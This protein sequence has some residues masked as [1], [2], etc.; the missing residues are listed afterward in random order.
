MTIIVLL[1]SLLM[2]LSF[3]VGSFLTKKIKSKA[4]SYFSLSLA[5]MIFMAVLFTDIVPEIVEQTTT[6][7]QLCL[8]I[9]S[10][11]FG[12]GILFII[13][14]FVPHHHHEHE[15]N[16]EN[17]AEH[18][19]HLYHIGLLTLISVLMHNM[20]EG[21]AFYT[22]AMASIKSALIA[23]GGIALH[24]IP[25]GIEIST[26]FKNK[27]DNALLRN[28]LLILSG[29][30]GASIGFLIGEL[31]TT[32]NICILSVTCGMMLYTGL[33]ELGSETIKDIKEKGIIE[34]L[35]VGAIIFVLMIM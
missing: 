5:F 26:S 11:I 23:A 1:L 7:N 22:I 28:M 6:Y 2:G 4:L 10:I 18:K 34:G 25:L 24:N 29:T 15:H 35:L 9:C 21:I 33:I 3:I 8:V 32:L 14:L 20:F 16:D 13:D 19:K 17:K 12:I 31:N 27:K 30:V